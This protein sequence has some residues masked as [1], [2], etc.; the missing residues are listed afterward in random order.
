M[1]RARLGRSTPESDSVAPP[2]GPGGRGTPGRQSWGRPP[3]GRTPA[4]VQARR[5]GSTLSGRQ[6]GGD[7][8]PPA[9]LWGRGP[10]GRPPG[11]SAE[12]GAP[13]GP[14][15]P[16][17]PL[18]PG[19]RRAVVG[20]AFAAGRGR[21][22]HRVQRDLVRHVPAAASPPLPDP[23][24]LTPLPPPSPLSSNPAEALLASPSPPPAESGPD[25]VT[26]RRGSMTTPRGAGVS[27]RRR[28]PRP[29]PRRRG[30]TDVTPR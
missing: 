23:P 28:R 9:G 8:G 5:L 25:G 30:P 3:R 6:T 14:S 10:H 26:T 16:A 11:S 15:L 4:R 27:W 20:R 12:G 24:R 19:P 21:A 7:P 2:R 18:G 22:A 29:R 13:G 1:T 17:G